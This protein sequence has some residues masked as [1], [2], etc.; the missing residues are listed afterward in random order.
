M[1]VP[2]P[3]ARPP[4]VPAQPGAAGAERWSPRASAPGLRKCSGALGGR[5]WRLSPL[6][7]GPASALNPKPSWTS[8]APPLEA[9][10][11][12]PLRAP[13]GAFRGAQALR[14]APRPGP[15]THREARSFTASLSS[16]SWTHR[17]AAARTDGGAGGR[18]SRGGRGRGRTFLLRWAWGGRSRGGGTLTPVWAR[19]PCPPA[20]LSSGYPAGAA[21]VWG[22]GAPARPQRPTGGLPD[23]VGAEHGMR[24]GG[25]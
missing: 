22:R 13:Q 1:R 14:P 6:G 19:K 11:L 3:P 24:E 10:S 17:P 15:P 2:P 23:A 20:C 9:P 18:R 12:A 25:R 16:P 5:E 21:A 8:A 4:S 7:P